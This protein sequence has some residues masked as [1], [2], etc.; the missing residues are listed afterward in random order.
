MQERYIHWWTS[1][2]SRDFEMLVFGN[3]GG[4]PLT[5]FRCGW[6]TF[7]I[8]KASRIGSTTGNGAGTI[9]IIGA[10]CCRIIYRKS[11]NT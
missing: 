11:N 3:D 10:T 1:H 9:G 2:L 4:L 8:P 5:I 6:P 7:S